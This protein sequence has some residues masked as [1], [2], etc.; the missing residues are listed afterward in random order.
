MDRP[1]FNIYIG[2]DEFDYHILF[3]LMEK[4]H[5]E[6]FPKVPITQTHKIDIPDKSHEAPQEN[7]TSLVLGGQQEN[8]GVLFEALILESEFNRCEYE[9]RSD[10]LLGTPIS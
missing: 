4:K 3:E 10:M 8:H 6:G 1:P 9:I 2:F 5:S 7:R